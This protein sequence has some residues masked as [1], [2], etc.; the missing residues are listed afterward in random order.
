MTKRKDPPDSPT[1]P[2]ATPPNVLKLHRGGADRPAH[3]RA[4]ACGDDHDDPCDGCDDDGCTCC[5][6][7]NGDDGEC[8]CP[9]CSG[10]SGGDVAIVI[11]ERLL[12]LLL[13]LGQYRKLTNLPDAPAILDKLEEA[14]LRSLDVAASGVSQTTLEQIGDSDDEP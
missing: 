13:A 9:E 8:D 14:L 6:N 5:D 3:T 2:E 7:Y 1:T 4:P 11:A 10:A 12:D